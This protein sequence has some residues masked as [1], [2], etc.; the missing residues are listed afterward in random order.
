MCPTSVC[1]MSV[2]KPTR[3]ACGRQGREDGISALGAEARADTAPQSGDGGTQQR[4][5]EIERSPD[6]L[7]LSEKVAL[8]PHPLCIDAEVDTPFSPVLLSQAKDIA[9][10]KGEQHDTKTC[11]RQIGSYGW[12]STADTQE[13]QGSGCERGQY[14]FI[15]RDMLAE[16]FGYDE[17]LD[18]TS[19]FAI[20]G[21]YCDLAIKLD[22][23]GGVL[24]LRPK[25]SA[26]I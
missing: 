5:R 7:S 8:F 20:K 23:S 9:E 22:G 15:I 19:E 13:R 26:S 1:V 3:D 25:L 17:L 10:A 6:T 16:V 4:G 21:T 11:F 24:G 18:I 12:E 14:V 2:T